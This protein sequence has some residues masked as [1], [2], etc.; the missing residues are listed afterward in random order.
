MLVNMTW[1]LMLLCYEL[2]KINCGKC[3]ILGVYDVM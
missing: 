1:E 2:V 3:F